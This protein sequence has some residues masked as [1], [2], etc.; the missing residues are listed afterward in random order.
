[1]GFFL[2]KKYEGKPILA[3]TAPEWYGTFV[4]HMNA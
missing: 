2:I 4:A 1:M 3:H